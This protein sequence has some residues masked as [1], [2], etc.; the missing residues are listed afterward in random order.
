MQVAIALLIRKEDSIAV[1]LPA[2][3]YDV[4]SGVFDISHALDNA[5]AVA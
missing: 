5:A 2:E 4:I 1:R 3:L